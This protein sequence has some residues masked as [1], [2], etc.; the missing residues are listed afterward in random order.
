MVLL[1]GIFLGLA[2]FTKIPAFTMIPLV[3]FLLVYGPNRNNDN[4][5]IDN[6]SN[7]TEKKTK[8]KAL[9]LW[10]IPVILIPSIWPIYSLSIGQFN[11]LIEGAILQTQRQDKSLSDSVNALFQIDPILMIIGIAGIGFSAA[12]KETSFF[13]YGLSHLW[14][15][16]LV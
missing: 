11:L 3:A 16:L 13:C 9:G 4:N 5:R 6:K 14:Y 1:S 2:I 10:L 12:I 8:L 7:R 15:S